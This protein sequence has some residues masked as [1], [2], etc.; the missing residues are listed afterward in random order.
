MSSSSGPS[1]VAPAEVPEALLN[2]R[3]RRVD[4]RFLLPLPRV[5]RAI[6]YAAGDLREGVTLIADRVVEPESAAA[7]D[8]DL[9]VV[10]DPDAATLR[11]AVAAL[12]PGGS[13]TSNGPAPDWP[14][15][16]G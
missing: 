16:A 14:A 2:R 10:V 13:A 12:R 7:A 3:L 9:A 6:C 8:C 5:A 11:A 1:T 15:R 4:W